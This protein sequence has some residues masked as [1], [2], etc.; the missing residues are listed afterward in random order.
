MYFSGSDR[1]SKKK[2]KQKKTNNKKLIHAEAEKQ[3]TK[4]P[5]KTGG[6]NSSKLYYMLE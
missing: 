3:L 1:A 5:S 6:L 2:E 4:T